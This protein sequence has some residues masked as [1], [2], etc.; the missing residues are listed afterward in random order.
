MTPQFTPL[1]FTIVDRIGGTYVAPSR[2]ICEILKVVAL[3]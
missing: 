2:V 3:A 1:H